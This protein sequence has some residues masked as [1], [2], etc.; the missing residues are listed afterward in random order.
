MMQRAIIAL[1]IC[2]LLFAAIPAAAKD[3]YPTPSFQGEELQKLRE[4][5][6]TWVGQKI[7]SANVDQVKEFL[8]ESMYAMM[9]DSERWGDSWFTV[10]AYQEIPPSPGLLKFTKQYYG[11]TKVGPNGEILNYTSGVPFP[12]TTS[13]IEMA[14][15]FR[16]RTMS[17]GIK[18]DEYGYI[19]DG[20]LKYDMNVKINNMYN[21]FASRTDTPPVPAYESNPKQIWRAFQMLQLAPPEVRDFRVMEINYL[22]RMKPFDSWFWMPSIRRVRRRSTTERQDAQ[23]G[24]DFCGYD[25]FGW[26]GPV[27]INKYRYIGQKDLLMA[28]HDDSTKLEHTPGDCLWDGVQRERVKMHLVE[29]VNEDKNFLY[30]KMIWYL[31]PETWQMIYSDRYDRRGNLWKVMDQMGNVGKGYNGVPISTFSANQMIDVQRK[32]STNAKVTFELGQQ[33]DERIFTLQYLQKRGY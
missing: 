16:E 24:A 12:D 20:R 9:K 11:Q 33:L 21:Y 25:N 7:S 6:K 5:E 31:D 32:H 30:T 4:W 17:D 1:G 28:R 2:A 14:H 29:A 22:D 10:V 18:T 13:A 8:P 19:V 27:Q 23:G 26:D 3:V 15:N